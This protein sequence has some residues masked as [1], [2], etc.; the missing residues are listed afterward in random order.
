MTH[1]RFLKLT[2]RRY[3]K[4]DPQ[5]LLKNWPTNF[6]QKLSHK[7]HSKLTHKRYAKI[8]PQLLLKK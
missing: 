5:L 6:T 8:D 4:S 3:S 1:K 2:Y 7:R